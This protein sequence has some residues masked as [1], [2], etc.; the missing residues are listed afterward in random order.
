MLPVLV[1]GEHGPGDVFEHEFSP[2][3]ERTNV[4]SGL[5]QVEPVTYEVIG[6]N[7]VY[8]HGKGERFQAQLLMEQEKHLVDAGH[9]R[10]VEEDRKPD[11]ATEAS[12]RA[13]RGHK[14]ASEKED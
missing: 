4:E 1:N 10:V 8:D 2:E 13:S 9:V 5:I 12:P 6:E 7:R 3:D 11:Q 14:K